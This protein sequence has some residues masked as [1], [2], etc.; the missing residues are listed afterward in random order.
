MTDPAADDADAEVLSKEGEEKVENQS[1]TAVA[2]D[3]EV[4]GKKEEKDDANTEE[5]AEKEE[6]KE[7]KPKPKITMENWPLRDISEPHPNDILYGRGG[8][9]KC[10]RQSLRG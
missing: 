2:D 6:I 9:Y 7:E 4:S 8:E 1:M 3:E 10:M 5:A